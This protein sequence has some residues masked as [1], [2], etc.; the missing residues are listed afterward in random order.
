[1]ACVGWAYIILFSAVNTL[2]GHYLPLFITVHRAST[3]QR[4]RLVPCFLSLRTVS[5]LCSTASHHSAAFLR[6]GTVAVLHDHP[7]IQSVTRFCAVAIL[8][9]SWSRVFVLWQ[10][11][12]PSFSPCGTGIFMQFSVPVYKLKLLKE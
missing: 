11:F 1:M 4:D 7:A 6:F 12:G 10:T 8:Q 2:F 3:A 9:Y 5:V